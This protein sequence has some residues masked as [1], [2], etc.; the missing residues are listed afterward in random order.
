LTYTILIQ[1]TETSVQTHISK[2]LH[3]TAGVS[4]RPRET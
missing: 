3:M 1:K 2:H 4:R